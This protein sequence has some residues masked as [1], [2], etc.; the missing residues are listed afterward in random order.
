M[1]EATRFQVERW[2]GPDGKI[3]R[4]IGEL[5]TD[6]Y[7]TKCG[8]PISHCEVYLTDEEEDVTC[9]ACLEEPLLF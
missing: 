5:I 8:L 3:H 6:K 4:V 1:R 9:T 2:T 7:S